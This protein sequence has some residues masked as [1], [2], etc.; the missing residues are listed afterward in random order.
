MKKTLKK[1]ITTSLVLLLSQ[2]AFAIKNQSNFTCPSVGSIERAGVDQ[3]F[4]EGDGVWDAGKIH[5]PY[6]GTAGDWGLLVFGLTGENNDQV[7]DQ[8]NKAL[9]TLVFQYLVVDRA[10]AIFCVYKGTAGGRDMEA[11]A[12]WGPTQQNAKGYSLAQMKH[13]MHK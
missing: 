1:I 11:W 7:L 5:A 6:D 3:A 8:A 10:P 9:S 4:Y 2:S 13:L 12:V